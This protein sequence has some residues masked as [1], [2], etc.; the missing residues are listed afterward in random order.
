MTV[1][2]LDTIRDLPSQDGLY[3]ILREIARRSDRG[4]LDSFYP[5]TGLLRRELYPKHVRM[6]NAGAEYDERVVMGGNRVGKTTSI[7][8]YETALHLTGLYPHWW[9]GHRFARPILAWACG[10]K[11]VKVR[12]VNQKILLGRLKSLQGVTTSDGGLVPTRMIEKIARKNGVT[13]AVDTVVIRHAKGHE[14]V[15][16][17]KS[18]EEGRT[19]FEAEE[20]HWAWLDEEPPKPIY[21]E[22]KMR[23]LTTQGH[24]MSTLTPVEG[25]TETV[26]ALLEGTDII[27]SGSRSMQ[28]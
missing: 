16:A 8:G 13:D 19:A 26:Q 3:L 22:V 21:D 14:N 20:I 1:L 23:L 25:M 7:G 27:A 2:S 17:F 15:L 6:L 28:G 18:Y 24:I 5:D 10:T 11:S 4:G 12:D 9:Q